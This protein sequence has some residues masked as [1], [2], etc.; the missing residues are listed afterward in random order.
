MLISSLSSGYQ[1]SCDGLMEVV[2]VAL[3]VV[4]VEVVVVVAGV[5][6]GAHSNSI[7]TQQSTA[8]SNVHVFTFAGNIIQGSG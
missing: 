4:D 7:A 3:V 8:L 2:V 6:M 5:V 1:Y